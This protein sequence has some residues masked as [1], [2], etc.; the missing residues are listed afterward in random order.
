MGMQIEKL[1]TEA[2]LR[3]FDLRQADP[4]PS[5]ISNLDIPESVDLVSPPPV[6]TASRL[7]A[8]DHRRRRTWALFN[9]RVFIFSK[10]EWLSS[11][12]KSDGWEWRI[13]GW[14][15]LSTILEISIASRCC[16][17]MC[18][19]KCKKSPWI[20]VVQFVLLRWLSS[21]FFT[22]FALVH[23]SYFFRLIL[24]K[25]SLKCRHIPWWGRRRWVPT[26][27]WAHVRFLLAP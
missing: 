19:C 15:C 20:G 16:L 23:V 21:A 1:K 10:R 26:V 3:E 9:L 13:R 18:I 27:P 4:G 14:L 6:R 11:E 24:C 5:M 25:I 22:N 17:F 12:L 7:T 8:S 2:Q